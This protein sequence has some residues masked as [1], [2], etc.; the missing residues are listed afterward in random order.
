MKHNLPAPRMGSLVPGHMRHEGGSPMSYEPRRDGEVGFRRGGV[1]P[2]PWK[3]PTAPVQ[4]R[5]A[6][7]PN[8][9]A[10]RA[11]PV[12]PAGGERAEWFLATVIHYHTE[13]DDDGDECDSC[14][15]LSNPHV[16]V[17][18]R[19]THFEWA[20]CEAHPTEKEAEE[21]LERFAREQ[22][23]EDIEHFTEQCFGCGEGGWLAEV[24]P[25]SIM[26]AEASPAR[27]RAPAGR[28]LQ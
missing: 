5:F 12:L 9:P 8:P 11:E 26:G 24:Q 22:G 14:A 18:E 16:H 10:P 2:A 1:G 15:G 13:L 25:V 17:Y 28:P 3:T 27:S 21:A 4:P 19:V 6:D 20:F 7:A 23:A